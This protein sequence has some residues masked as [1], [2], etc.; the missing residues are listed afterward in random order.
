MPFWKTVPI[1][2][3][4]EVL[5]LQW[6]ILETP[7]GRRHFVGRGQRDYSGRV[8]SNDSGFDRGS[9][10]VTT[11]S[12]RIYQLVGP[13]GWSADLQYVWEHYCAVNHVTSHTD[14]TAPMRSEHQNDDA[15]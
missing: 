8:K 13:N 6:S 3:E 14:V 1:A 15:R 4:P 5:L 9:L 10:R 11:R 2:H 7:G 12:R